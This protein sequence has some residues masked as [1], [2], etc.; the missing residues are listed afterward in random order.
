MKT[1]IETIKKIEESYTIYP[2][3]RV[4]SKK[5]HRWIKPTIG[6]GGEV[7]YHLNNPNISIGMGRLV[8]LKYI[9]NPR[10]YT[11]VEHLDSNRM[12]NDRG[13]LGWC[14]RAKNYHKSGNPNNNSSSNLGVQSKSKNRSYPRTKSARKKNPRD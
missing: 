12:N 5:T 10:N 8:A 9:P 13:N 4:Y 2:D 11:D 3:G 6:W 14:S 1:T 7:F